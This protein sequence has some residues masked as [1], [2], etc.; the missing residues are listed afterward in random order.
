MKMKENTLDNV[1]VKELKRFA[2]LIRR[3]DLPRKYWNLRTIFNNLGIDALIKVERQAQ[4]DQM[5]RLLEAVDCDYAALP[6]E[7][8]DELL[9]LIHHSR[10]LTVQSSVAQCFEELNSL[11]A[12]DRLVDYVAEVQKS[13]DEMSVSCIIFN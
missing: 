11:S 3:K 13:L 2:P 7:C 8:L 5:V 10:C 1:I 12:L 4:P 6:F 9:S